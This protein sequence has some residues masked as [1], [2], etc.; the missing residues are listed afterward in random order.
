MI[1]IKKGLQMEEPISYKYRELSGWWHIFGVIITVAV[2]LYHFIDVPNFGL[3]YFIFRYIHW[4][5]IAVLVFIYFPALKNSRRDRPTAIDLACTLGCIAV[6]TYVLFNYD[7]IISRLEAPVI[8]DLVLGALFILLVLE[9]GRRTAGVPLVVFAVVFLAYALFGQAMPGLLKHQGYHAT[10]IISHLYLNANVI[11]AYL[12]SLSL[13]LVPFVILGSF[14]QKAD[15]GLLFQDLSLLMNGYFTGAPRRPSLLFSGLVGSFTGSSTANVTNTGSVTVPLMK[16]YGY[17]PAFAG[18]V[19]VVASA[20]GQILP[21]VMGVAAFVIADYIGVP[22]EKVILAALVPAILYFIT[23]YFMVH[24]RAL[25]D[26]IPPVTQE[27][28]PEFSKVIIRAVIIFTP[29]VFLV[30]LLILGFSPPRAVFVSLLLIIA[31]SWF[32]ADMRMGLKK[33][34]EALLSGMKKAVEIVAALAVAAI[35]ISILMMTGLSL[36]FI[37]MIDMWS[38]GSLPVALAITLGVSLFFGM[39]IPTVA[40]YM[41]LA[42]LAAPALVF[43]GTPLLATH[44]LILYFAAASD[45][46]PPL[47]LASY[48]VE[49]RSDT[50]PLLVSLEAFKLGL[51]LYILPVCFVYGA[52]LLL[53]GNSSEIIIAFATALLGCTGLGAAMQGYFVRELSYCYRVLLFVGSL[54]LIDVGWIWDLIGLFLVGGIFLLNHRSKKLFA[55]NQEI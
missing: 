41:L 1:E 17:N 13:R 3:P 5:L 12:L 37:V 32:K 40:K 48:A 2:A 55:Q 26:G 43:M 4:M 29:L 45:I 25:K 27:E 50:P 33:I 42:T 51:A 54:M 23:L 36:N 30:A 10:Q 46:T 31:L 34:L 8:T 19:E 52:S 22:Y 14:L 21:P 9:G 11:F 6:G 47:G 38:S 49:D 28:R 20:G 44:L 18:G 35:M 16:N 24:F 53:Q 39:G 15:A 7:V